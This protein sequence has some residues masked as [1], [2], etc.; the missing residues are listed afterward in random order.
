MLQLLAQGLGTNAIAEM[1][2]VRPITVR[3]HIYRIL[4]MMGVHSRLEAVLAASR[5]GLL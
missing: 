3:N 5:R 1:L 2:V 4:A